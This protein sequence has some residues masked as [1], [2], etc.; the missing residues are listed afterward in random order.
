MAS[1]ADDRT[2]CKLFPRRIGCRFFQLCR[3]LAAHGLRI[4]ALIEGLI[5]DEVPFT[6]S[7]HANACH[8]KMSLVTYNL[9]NRLPDDVLLVIF[10]EL[11]EEGLLRCETVCRQW[12]NVLL[13]GRPWKILF[14]RQIVSS[15]LWRSVLQNFGVDVN[16]LENVHYRGLC[17]AI[18]RQLNKI[19][20]N[21]RTGNFEEVEEISLYDRKIYSVTNDF[22][23]IISSVTNRSYDKEFLFF[24]RRSQ[25]FTGSVIPLGWRGVTNTEIVVLWTK[26][27]SKS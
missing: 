11:D 10:D 26:K 18:L 21:W 19:N 14:R 20:R 15:Q 8:V 27:T 16:K 25:R 6:V 1:L 13:S 17:R 5:K 22:I 2:V 9:G 24:D 4:N 23:V 3:H 7:F 12:R